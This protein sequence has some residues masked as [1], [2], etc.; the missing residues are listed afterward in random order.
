MAR[1]KLL[2]VSSLL[3]LVVLT[4]A[5]IGVCG[6]DLYVQILSIK[7]DVFSLTKSL[8]ILSGAL[9]A[10]TIASVSILSARKLRIN[11]QLN[12]IPK[13]HL[14]LAPADMPTRAFFAHTQ[15]KLSE[16]AAIRAALKPLPEEQH[17]DG[18][19]VVEGG[20]GARV[21]FRTAIRRTL[22][23]LSTSCFAF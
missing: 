15:H 22:E 21:H 5:L 20:G 2:S 17:V 4:F 6:L 7:N 11:T 3:A 14:P 10:L 16:T 18:Y 12:A 9:A 13:L 8:F 19:G 1:I 23:V